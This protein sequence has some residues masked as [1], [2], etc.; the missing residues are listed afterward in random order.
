MVTRRQQGITPAR[1]VRVSDEVWE[2]ARERATSEG[3]TL[4]RV[5]VSILEGYGQGKV[6]LPTVHVDYD[7][8]IGDD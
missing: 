6:N 7:T 4:T 5:I 1:S 3:V 2:A 8:V